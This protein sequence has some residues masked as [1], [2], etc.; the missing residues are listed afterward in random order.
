MS[1]KLSVLVWSA[2]PLEPVF[3]PLVTAIRECQV[4]V[5]IDERGEQFL[6]TSVQHESLNMSLY[7]CPLSVIFIPSTDALVDDYPHVWRVIATT[8]PMNPMK[9]SVIVTESQTALGSD[10]W[11]KRWGVPYD[12]PMVAGN[13][14]ALASRLKWILALNEDSAL[15]STF[16]E[17]GDYSPIELY[18]RACALYF[19]Q[20]YEEAQA[21]MSTLIS[22]HYA[23]TG[24]QTSYAHIL[25]ARS[26]WSRCLAQSQR[27]L[28]LNDGRV[29]AMLSWGMSLL[30]LGEPR[31]ALRKFDRVISV[32]KDY[33]MAWLGR[34]RALAALGE[35]AEAIRAYERTA[36]I[37]P[38]NPWAYENDYVQQEAKNE[39]EKIE[40]V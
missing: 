22:S 15:L 35:T 23:H 3:A 5:R 7:L 17:R 14:P 29:M 36:T 2:G 10:A 30:E 38:A 11:A 40:H 20:R 25:L 9:V 1:T 31:A 34:A 13:D 24:L 26:L 8:R 27:A 39:K 16:P 28:Q 18:S 19:Q 6:A 12:W 21:L 33:G 32:T 37:E 4:D